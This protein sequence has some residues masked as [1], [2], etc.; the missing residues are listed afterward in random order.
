MSFE[1]AHDVKW[2]WFTWHW[3]C[4]ERCSRKWSN[5]FPCNLFPKYHALS[6]FLFFTKHDTWTKQ[7]ENISKYNLKM[8]MSLN[9]DDSHAIGNALRRHVKKWCNMFSL[10]LFS[11]SY[12]SSKFWKYDKTWHM[13]KNGW[14][15]FWVVFWRCDWG[16]T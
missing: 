9:G 10:D 5:M 7:H 13:T 3:R 8:E 1:S 6:K 16:W 11:K 2:K 4:F 14:K 15:Y 12:A